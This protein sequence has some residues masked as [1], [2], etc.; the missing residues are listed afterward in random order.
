MNTNG[1]PAAG[2]SRSRGSSPQT[3][4]RQQSAIGERSGWQAA[5]DCDPAIV[6]DPSWGDQ[7]VFRYYRAQLAA[8]CRKGSGTADALARF[9]AVNHAIEQRLREK[10][11][12]LMRQIDQPDE[13]RRDRVS[14]IDAD[15][16]A[17]VEPR[18]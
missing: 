16:S 15:A 14:P 9:R 6:V 10:L 13:A 7:R 1:S 11:P 3:A 2:E 8:V 5:T 18:L 4:E 12:H 17:G